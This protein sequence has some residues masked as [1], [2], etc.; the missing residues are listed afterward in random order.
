MVAPIKIT[1]LTHHK[2]FGK[3]SN[4]GRVV[5]QVLGAEAEQIRWDRLEPPAQLVAEIAAGG[6]ALVYP[7]SEHEEIGD[8]SEIS[9][10]VVIDGT[11]LTARK[12][13]QRSPYLHH[14]RRVSLQ[15]E[16]P[17]RYNLR[18]HQ[19]EDGLCTAECVVEVL[20][21]VGRSEQA[22]ELQRAFLAF[23]KPERRLPLAVALAAAQAQ[24]LADQGLAM[25]ERAS[26]ARS[27]SPASDSGPSTEPTT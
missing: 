15:P 25:P 6:V 23:Q 21:G 22:E 12:I 27:A 3:R 9:Q 16:L 19:K 24:A 10:F 8:L 14:L 26:S 20:R 2:E 1:L 4:T 17:S 18:K 11:W 5:V 13:Y 7:G